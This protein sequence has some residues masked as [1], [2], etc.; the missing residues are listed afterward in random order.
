MPDH[1]VSGYFEQWRA[2]VQIK[3]ST[4]KLVAGMHRRNQCSLALRV[5]CLHAAERRA[6]RVFRQK[7]VVFR[8]VRAKRSAFVSWRRYT[9]REDQHRRRYLGAI[10]ILKNTFLR[11]MM[12]GFAKA[13]RRERYVSLVSERVSCRLQ[14]NSLTSSLR[15]WIYSVYIARDVDDVRELN[16]PKAQPPPPV[17]RA[18][19]VATP[20]SSCQCWSKPVSNIAHDVTRSRT[21][22]WRGCGRLLSRSLSTFR[23]G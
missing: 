14:R 23:P 8:A 9:D 19:Q 21:L 17:N 5:L 15:R 2:L 22:S 10:L 11:R 13:A 12:R 7:K 4:L 6:V 1:V 16:E 18:V 3:A 20:I